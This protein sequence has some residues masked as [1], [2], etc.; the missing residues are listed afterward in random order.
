MIAGTDLQ[1]IPL[2]RLDH[3]PRYKQPVDMDQ[4]VVTAVRSAIQP[5]VP[6]KKKREKL[7]ALC[8][9]PPST[10]KARGQNYKRGLCL[11]EVCT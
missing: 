6:A 4:P 2:K 5:P 9:T 7:S 1:R 10:I 3:T 8:K 11:G